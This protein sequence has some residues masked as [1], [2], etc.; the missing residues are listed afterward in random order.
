MF[1]RK[2]AFFQKNLKKSINQFVKNDKDINKKK[3]ISNKK[4]VK[5][6]KD[7]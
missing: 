4:E 5:N 1:L 6:V 2:N 3:Q 7:I